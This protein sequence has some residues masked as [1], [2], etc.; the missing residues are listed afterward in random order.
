MRQTRQVYPTI[1]GW[2]SFCTAT[3]VTNVTFVTNAWHLWQLHKL[4]CSLQ[5]LHSHIKTWNYLW[6]DNCNGHKRSCSSCVCQISFAWPLWCYRYFCC[7][8]LFLQF[9]VH[10][11]WYLSK[12]CSRFNV[13]AAC[14][15]LCVLLKFERSV[16]GMYEMCPCQCQLWHLLLLLIDRV[17]FSTFP[18]VCTQHQCAVWQG[19]SQHVP[20]CDKVGQS[21]LLHVL[22][23]FL[24][25][26]FLCLCLCLC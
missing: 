20:G 17:H 13:S 4:P 5:K 24:C 23:L 7:I 6:H 8:L 1:A 11:R 16:E 9:T 22:F 15:C 14:Q 10:D 26:C 21:Q 12:T 19:A 18:L 3:F 25:V 2:L